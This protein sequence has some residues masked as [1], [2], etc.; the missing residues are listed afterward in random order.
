[1][2]CVRLLYTLTNAVS[3]ENQIGAR[4]DSAEVVTYVTSIEA[5]YSLCSFWMHFMMYSTTFSSM[6]MKEPAPGPPF[7][8][9]KKKRFGILGAHNDIYASGCGVQTSSRVTP[10]RPTYGV[11]AELKEL[12]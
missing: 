10:P 2:L 11:E 3:T 5:M 6:A 7:G 4:R 9:R 8:P 1:M 12:D